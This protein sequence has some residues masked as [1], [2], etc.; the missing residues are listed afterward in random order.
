MAAPFTTYDQVGQAEDVED[1][2]WDISPT[3]VPFS[4]SIGTLSVSA[5][6]HQWQ[7]DTLAAPA[8]NSAIEGADAAF[9][10]LDPTVMLDNNTQ[11]LQKTVQT[12]GTSDAI[13]TYGRAQE[14]AY[15]V[16]KKGRELTRD[17]EHAFVGDVTGAKADGSEAAPRTM[18]P[19]YAFIPAANTDENAG[20]LR[21][22]SE[23]QVLA[24]LESTY[25]LGG[26]P[27][28]MHVSPSKAIDVANFAYRSDGAGATER[29]RD[30]GDS[31]TLVNAVDIYVSPFGMLAVV[32]NRWVDPSAVLLVDT[33][34][35]KRGILRPMRTYPIAKTGDSE[36]RQLLTECTL[37]AQ[38][39]ESSGVILDLNA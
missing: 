23:A 11:I 8:A 4:S 14:L 27:D 20:V 26:E 32:I 25:V 5:V 37:V 3:D 39:P 15:Q 35:W 10:D 6:N 7:T 22:F 31:K 30:I 38:S 34:Y 18:D 1:I 12:S 28:Q 16:A 2:I 29:H 13:R 36:K 19:Y 17:I 9:I 21:D 33:Q 24:V